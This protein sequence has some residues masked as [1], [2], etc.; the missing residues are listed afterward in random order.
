MSQFRI[1][2]VDT[3][4]N[5][6]AMLLPGSEGERDFITAITRAIMTNGLVD[7]IVSNARVLGVGL[8]KSEAT[9]EVA[10]RASVESVLRDAIHA[11]VADAIHALKLEVH[12]GA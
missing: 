1:S 5:R 9:V 4:N 8:F 11:G 10:I 6:T 7:E 12:P 3:L 2:V